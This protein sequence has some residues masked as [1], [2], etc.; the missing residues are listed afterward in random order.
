MYMFTIV[1]TKHINCELLWLKECNRVKSLHFITGYSISTINDTH[2][3]AQILG[4]YVVTSSL[5]NMWDTGK[6]N[7]LQSILE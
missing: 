7:T 2:N 1:A 5:V 3:E 4:I 6:L